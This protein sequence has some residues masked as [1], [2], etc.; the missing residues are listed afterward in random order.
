LNNLTETDR[1]CPIEDACRGCKCYFLYHPDAAE[2]GEAPEIIKGVR[3]RM[4]LEEQAPV[5]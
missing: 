5:Y 3:F 2:S 4:V 1:R